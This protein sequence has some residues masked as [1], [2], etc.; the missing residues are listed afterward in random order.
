MNIIIGIKYIQDDI[1][2][3]TVAFGKNIFDNNRNKIYKNIF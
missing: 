2:I 1:N 3:F